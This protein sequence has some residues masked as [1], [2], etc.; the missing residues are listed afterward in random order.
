M[1][2]RLRSPRVAIAKPGTLLHVNYLVPPPS[3]TQL[4]V[5]RG[6]DQDCAQGTHQRC[7]RFGAG[8]GAK[9]DGRLGAKVAAELA[10]GI[11]SKR[12][13]RRVGQ[14]TKTRDRKWSDKPV[15]RPRKRA[16]KGDLVFREYSQCSRRWVE[17]RERE[18]GV[19]SDVEK[20]HG[21]EPPRP[22]FGERGR[23]MHLDQVFIPVQTP[24]VRVSAF[25]TPAS[26]S[27]SEASASQTKLIGC[28]EMV[29]TAA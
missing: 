29:S 21:T 3:T 1:R 12:P 25:S 23:P 7:G 5:A 18:S 15:S 2:N 9:V 20:S 26:S 11:H 27:C 13:R 8:A 6:P 17:G 28:P 10:A 4:P 14:E 24:P 19:R 22:I 16:K